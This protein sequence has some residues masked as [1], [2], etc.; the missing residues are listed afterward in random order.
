MSKARELAELSRTV[1]DSADATAITIN[2]SE[3]VTFADDI[4]LADGKKAVFGAGSDA[5]LHSDGSAGYARGFVLQNT[6]GNKDVLSFVDGGAATLFHDNAAKLATTATGIQVTGNISN[7]SGSLI[8]DVASTTIIDSASS[9]QLVLKYS[10]TEYGTLFH[11]S[12]HYYIQSQISDGDI[13]FRGKDGGSTITALTLNMSEAGEA[14]FNSDVLLG[15]SKVLRFGAD[16]DFRISF[17][18]SHGIIQNATSN[19]DIVFKGSDGGSSLNALVLDMSENGAAAFSGT[20]ASSVITAKSSGNTDSALIVQQTGSTD[21]WGLIPDNTNGNLEITR[22]GGGTAGTHFTVD[23]AGNVGI[24]NSNPSAY[25]KFLVDGTGNL[26]NANATSGAATFQLYEGGQGRFG[27]VTLDGSA[28][29]KFTTAGTERMRINSSG[30]VGINTTNPAQRFVVAEGTNQHG[31]ELAPGT[32]SYIQAYDR[33]TSDYGNLK[34]DAQTIQFGTDNGT[35]RMRIDS[36]GNLLVGTTDEATYNLTSGG[37]TALWANGLVSSAKSGAIVG[38]FN[39]TSSDG[40]I[41]QFRKNGTTVGSIGVTGTNDLYITTNTANHTGL[42]LGEGYY[43]PTDNSGAS[44]DNAVDLGLASVRYKDLYLSGVARLGTS[45]TYGTVE[46]KTNSDL[47]IVAN[48]GQVNGNPNIIFKSSNAGGTVTERMRID[49]TGAVIVNNSGGDAQMYFGGTSGTTRMYLARSG[50]DSLLWNVSNGVMRFGTNDTEAAR[51]DASQRLV[52]GGTT[53]S[54]E[55]YITKTS[56]GEIVRADNSQNNWSGV[57]YYSVIFGTGN[58]NGNTSLDRHFQGYA[59]GAT[60]FVVCGNGDV[61]NNNNSYG[62][63]SDLKLKENIVDSGSQWDDIKALRIRKYSMKDEHSDA[64]T[65]IGVIAQELEAAGMGGLVTEDADLDVDNN[66]LGT[67]T[68]Q[69]AYSVLYMKAV[70]ALQEAMER[71]ESLEAR[72]AALES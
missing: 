72:I 63:I 47:E 20:I 59:G 67:T 27:I 9:G 50:S 7:S 13:I 30:N 71:I 54:A 16:Q 18:G 32:L 37:G 1:S 57:M 8:I 44:A 51:I 68:K 62:A 48:A 12:N 5:T 36:S 6:A 3:E 29:A 41:L 65:Q 61:K 10:G 33:A 28:G 2:S 21:G 56:S 11:D 22:I 58:N 66:D 17:D 25:G 40:D 4:F 46:G 42:R 19:S 53:A 49:S 39:R 45:T 24:N 69:V 35:E 26:I 70:K 38:I 52:L 14:I 31:I 55:L 60:R 64:P 15:D 23:N 34:I 43:I